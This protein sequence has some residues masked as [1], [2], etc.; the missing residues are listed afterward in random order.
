MPYWI[1]FENANIILTN[2]LL[3]GPSLWYKDKIYWSI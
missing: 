1:R 2:D 3:L